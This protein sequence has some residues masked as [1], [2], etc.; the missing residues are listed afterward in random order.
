MGRNG[1]PRIEVAGFRRLFSIALERFCK[2]VLEYHEQSSSSG[3]V[4]GIN[5]DLWTIS[6]NERHLT[7]RSG[8]AAL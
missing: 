3:F 8:G 1:Y 4:V 6:G 7:D 2:R 5:L